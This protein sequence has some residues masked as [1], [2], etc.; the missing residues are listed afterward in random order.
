MVERCVREDSSSCDPSRITWD[1]RPRVMRLV[2]QRE[3]S[4]FM[5]LLTIW[6]SF[7]AMVLLNL[8]INKILM[9][10]RLNF[11]ILHVTMDIS[12]YENSMGQTPCCI[13]WSTHNHVINIKTQ[14]RWPQIYSH[15]NYFHSQSD[16]LFCDTLSICVTK[17][18]KDLKPSLTIWMCGIRCSVCN[19][20]WPIMIHTLHIILII[21]KE[22]W[23]IHT[24]Y[25]DF[26]DW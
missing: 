8:Y 25:G 12:G 14:C 3:E 9:K 16:L 4:I 13:M 15:W 11:C 22:I 24:W 19:M 26:S 23:S 18:Y 2:S 6:F 21:T 1:R 5:H 7:Y 10:T 20:E 17:K